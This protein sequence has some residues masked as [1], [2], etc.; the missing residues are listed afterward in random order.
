VKRRF[1]HLLAILLLP[2]L[3][4]AGEAK[5]TSFDGSWT[6]DWR[7]RSLARRDNRFAVVESTAGRYLRIDS[8]R[9]VSALWREVDC[10]VADMPVVSWRWKLQRAPDHGENERER[11]GDDYA[12]RLAVF[13]DGT[14]FDRRTKVVMYVW[15]LREPVGS[16]YES[17][18][19]SNVA[20]MVLRSGARDGERWRL[21]ERDLVADFERAFGE[22]PERVTGF[23]I[24]SDTDNTQSRATAFFS[25]LLLR[26][27]RDAEP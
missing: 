10:L 11:A 4:W 9:S 22:S 2:G 3:A 21:E 27:G 24:M 15:A 5:S 23:A 19:A 16:V 14:P 8:D 26:P 20:T 18:Y 13:F 17:P 7:E 6:S 25:D 12:A 1:G